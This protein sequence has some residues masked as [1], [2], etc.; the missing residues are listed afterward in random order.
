MTTPVH[1]PVLVAEVVEALGVKPGGSYIDGT[2]GAGGHSAAILD[3]AGAAGRILGIDADPDA[4]RLAETRLR[5]YGQAVVLVNDNFVNIDRVAREHGFVLPDGIL[6]DL[7]LSSMQVETAERGFSFQLDAPLDMRFSPAQEIT[8]AD[9]VNIYSETELA[10][11]LYEY[12]E[13]RHSRRI[14]KEI[15]RSRPVRMTRDL[16]QIV[17]RAVGGRYGRVHPATKTFQALRIAVNKELSNLET[18]LN[19]AVDL[20]GHGGR[21]VAISY[22]SLED[23]IVKQFLKREAA[24]CIC[25]PGTPVCQCGHAPTVKLVSK[26]VIVPSDVEVLMNPRSR[27][28]RLRV[29]ERL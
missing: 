5:K 17:D 22:H 2:V 25:P 10:R 21:L 29:A 3:R 16:V 9:I 27:S 12:G 13:E 1:I 8:A 26:R 14:A 24:S 18:A 20:L 11:L 4:I 23:R 19:K 15:V 7:G 28:A 6:L